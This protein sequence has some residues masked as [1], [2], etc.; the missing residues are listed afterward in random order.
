MQILTQSSEKKCYF[1][2][3]VKYIHIAFQWPF[4]KSIYYER[5][6]CQQ[7]VSFK[8]YY[9]ECY[10]RYILGQYVEGFTWTKK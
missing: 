9:F 5:N 1:Y 7:K 10:L 3:Q 8:K 4:L 2:A 6:S